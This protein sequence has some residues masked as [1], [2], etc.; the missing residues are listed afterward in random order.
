MELAGVAP[1]EV[2]RA[3]IVVCGAVLQEMVR[4]HEEAVRYGHGGPLLPPAAG[5]PNDTGRRS[6]SWSGWPPRPPR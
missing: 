6:S 5:D 2:V 4:N 1:V 3:E